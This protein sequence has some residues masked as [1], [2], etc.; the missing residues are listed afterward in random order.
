MTKSTACRTLCRKDILLLTLFAVVLTFIVIFV[1]VQAITAELELLPFILAAA[2][3]ALGTLWGLL[4]QIGLYLRKN[5]DMVYW[6]EISA[7]DDNSE[8]KQHG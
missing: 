6:G 2:I 4:L 3:V 1:I 5:S 8:V 7:M